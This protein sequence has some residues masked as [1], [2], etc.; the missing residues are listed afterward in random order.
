MCLI[1]AEKRGRL[2]LFKILSN[3]VI[4]NNY[5]DQDI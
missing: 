3:T 5:L 4:S 1:F 2:K